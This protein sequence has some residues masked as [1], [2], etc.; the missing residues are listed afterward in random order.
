[1]DDK[2]N[3]NQEQADAYSMEQRL[4]LLSERFHANNWLSYS[5]L[6]A[7]AGLMIHDLA[8]KLASVRADRDERVAEMKRTELKRGTSQL[9]RTPMK[10]RTKADGNAE[11]TTEERLLV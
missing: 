9:K 3:T 4:V 10:K 2:E 1:M 11:G 7:D 6:V 8:K 5:A